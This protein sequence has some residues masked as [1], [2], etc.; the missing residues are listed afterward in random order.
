MLDH[1]S[2]K[3][4]GGISAEKKTDHFASDHFSGVKFWRK[5]DRTFCPPIILVSD[6]F[7]G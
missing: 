3:S 5:N 6:H 2:G 7:T 1:F 4:F